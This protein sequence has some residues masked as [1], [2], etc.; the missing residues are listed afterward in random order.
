[1]T[2]QTKTNQPFQCKIQQKNQIVLNVNLFQ[3]FGIHC[4]PKIKDIIHESKWRYITSDT[5]ITCILIF[6]LL[7][8]DSHT[9]I[10][11]IAQFIKNGLRQKN[12]R[13]SNEELRLW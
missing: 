11:E 6:V 9:I 2:N 13:W 3:K 7:E 8:Q 1:M 5:R 12:N 10:F 4:I